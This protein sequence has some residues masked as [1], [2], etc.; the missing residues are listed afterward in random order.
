MNQFLQNIFPN[1]PQESGV[2]LGFS[3]VL[4]NADWFDMPTGR[5]HFVDVVSPGQK[6]ATL[7]PAT[8]QSAMNHAQDMG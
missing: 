5:N 1:D 8:N 6:K 2:G 7:K 3:F 4:Q